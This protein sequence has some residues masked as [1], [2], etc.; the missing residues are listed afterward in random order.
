MTHVEGEMYVVA[1]SASCCPLW[2]GRVLFGN[3][4][5]QTRMVLAS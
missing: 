2:G 4:P 1:N 3:V 5:T